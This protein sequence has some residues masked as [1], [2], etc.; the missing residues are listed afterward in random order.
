[1]EWKSLNTRELWAVLSKDKGRLQVDA[2]IKREEGGFL[3]WNKL[4]WGIATFLTPHL[5]AEWVKMQQSEKQQA[6]NRVPQANATLPSTAWYTL[7]EERWQTEVQPS[8]VGKL[9]C[10]YQGSGAR[11]RKLT[12]LTQYFLQVMLQIF[13]I[14]RYELVLLLPM[15][16]EKH[17]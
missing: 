14:T 8:M 9:C 15:M 11:G 10:L 12:G 3:T 7:T 2:L 17:C 13:G 6:N 16:K 5:Q 4:P 1:M